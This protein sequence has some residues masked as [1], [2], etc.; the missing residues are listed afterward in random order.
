[1]EEAYTVLRPRFL[2]ALARLADQGLALN[3]LEA[4]DLIHDF[5][6]ERW[7]RVVQSYDPEKGAI[8]G[9]AYTAFVNFARSRIARLNRFR[10]TLIDLNEAIT[11]ESNLLSHDH[12]AEQNYDLKRLHHALDRIPA[13][14]R[15]M[16][17]DYF[18]AAQPSIR[19]L[20]RQ[21][22]LS[23]YA[24]QQRLAEAL[25]SL[26]VRLDKPDGLDEQAWQVSRTLLGRHYTL[27]QAASHHSL[28]THQTR[29]AHARTLHLLT[30][31]IQRAN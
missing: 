6:L 16:L 17:Q 23:R 24:V 25:G 29:Q 2:K 3:F 4:F 20:A 28:T 10:S 30:R 5:F 9:Y 26:V 14:D 11:T 8:E 7:D 1:M 19:A 18:S 21:H 31:L 12:T 15:T 13:G 27:E 22:Q